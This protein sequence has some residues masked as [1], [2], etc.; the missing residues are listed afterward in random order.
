VNEQVAHHRRTDEAGAAR[1][2]NRLILEAHGGAGVYSGLRE[3]R[4]LKRTD[5][6]AQVITA[7]ALAGAVCELAKGSMR[8]ATRAEGELLAARNTQPRSRAG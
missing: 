4:V 6:L 8:Y 5:E 2:K 3:C 1:D 7:T